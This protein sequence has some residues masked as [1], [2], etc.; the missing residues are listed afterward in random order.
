MFVVVIT[1]K[2]D[3]KNQRSWGYPV[4]PYC[5]FSKHVGMGQ[6]FWAKKDDVKTRK[7]QSGCDLLSTEDLNFTVHNI[8]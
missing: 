4:P 3:K 1:M 8:E 6:I 2:D 7:G 5:T